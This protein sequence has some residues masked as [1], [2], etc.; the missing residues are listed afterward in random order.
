MEMTSCPICGKIH[1]V[2]KDALCKACR[3]LV[4]IVYEKARN[5]L[6]DNPKD[7]MDAK[8]LA[9]AIDEDIRIIQMLMME[10]RFTGNPDDEHMLESEEEKKRKQLL[11]EIQK[12]LSSSSGESS[13]KYTSYGQDRHGR[14]E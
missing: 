8:Q 4:E 7:E 9:D 13:H 10:G 3:G 2:G 14:G 12:S 11:N 1:V 5:Y 6:R